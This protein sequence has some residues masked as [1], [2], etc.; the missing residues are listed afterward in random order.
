MFEDIFTKI[1]IEYDVLSNKWESK[2]A[3]FWLSL[4]IRYLGK[5]TTS[6][7]REEYHEEMIKAA[8]CI[9]IAIK[10]SEKEFK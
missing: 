6:S 2:D 5:G 9:I 7:T 8:A 1:K 4:I 10:R 3:F